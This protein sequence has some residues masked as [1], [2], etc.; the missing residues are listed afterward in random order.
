MKEVVQYDRTYTT[1][2]L[3][4]AVGVSSNRI[5]VLCAKGE[6]KAS[7]NEQG[8]WR[9][10]GSAYMNWVISH[11]PCRAAPEVWMTASQAARYCDVSTSTIL[12]WCRDRRIPNLEDDSPGVRMVGARMYLIHG[13][14]LR[15]MASWR[16]PKR[17][18]GNNDE[19]G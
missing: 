5:A 11:Y 9:I 7:R 16:G 15:K 4:E 19:A 18:R 6:L 17:K 3:A 10:L 13:S 14:A 2:E 1:R 8:H 12:S